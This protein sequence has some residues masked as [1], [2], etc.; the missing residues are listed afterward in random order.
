MRGLSSDVGDD[1]KV[2]VDSASPKTEEIETR[3]QWSPSHQKMTDSHDDQQER[4]LDV[5]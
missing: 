3:R 5:S 2:V 4:E 1:R